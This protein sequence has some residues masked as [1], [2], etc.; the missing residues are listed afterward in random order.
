[1][2]GITSIHNQL[3]SGN[4]FRLIRC[5]IEYAISDILRLSDMA[6]G[7]ATIKL[8]SE[9]LDSFRGIFGQALYKWCPNKA[10]MYGIDSDFVFR[11]KQSII[12]THQPDGPF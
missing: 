11:I 6:N 3:G 12:L 1:M 2:S 8:F 4:E 9:C 10:R 7:M 5:E